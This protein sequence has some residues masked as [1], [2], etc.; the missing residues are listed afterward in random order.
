M[1]HSHP[2]LPAPLTDPPPLQEQFTDFVRLGRA[3]RVHADLQPFCAETLTAALTTPEEMEAFYDSKV[4][5]TAPGDRG[6]RV[7]CGKLSIMI[8]G[9]E[10]A[11]WC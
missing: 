4:N 11:K 7:R 9:W 2:S 6:G 10:C 1:L 8:T 5:M 3:G